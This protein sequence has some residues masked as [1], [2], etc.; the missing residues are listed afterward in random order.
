MISCGRYPKRTKS[1]G[2]L[3]VPSATFAS[4]GLSAPSF[5]TPMAS[6][7]ATQA[8][9]SGDLT[10]LLADAHLTDDALLAVLS[11]R[12]RADL[13]FARISSTALVFLNPLKSLSIVNDASAKEYE[14]RCY[15]DT[16][17]GLADSRRPPQPHVFEQAAK[18]YLLM[19]RRAQSQAV[20]ARY[21]QR[22]ASFS[23]PF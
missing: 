11:A 3:T 8:T 14:E 7:L 10:D 17:L 16:R 13:P 12:F 21:V 23:S 2:S 4:H 6:P 9:S 15:K 20:I 22:P 5:S 19:R 18:I 1:A